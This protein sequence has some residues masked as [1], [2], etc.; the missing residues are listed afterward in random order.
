[1]E[2][3]IFMLFAKFELHKNKKKYSKLCIIILR[4]VQILSTAYCFS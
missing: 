3:K 4:I 2:L 1:M